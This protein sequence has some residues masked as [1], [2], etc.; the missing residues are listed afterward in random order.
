LTKFCRLCGRLLED[1]DRFCDRCGTVQ[2]PEPP[3]P[4]QYPYVGPPQPPP[5]WP[6]EQP[7]TPPTVQ[8]REPAQAQAP[9]PP[10]PT[11]P[12]TA[13]PTRTIPI[14]RVPTPSYVDLP[15]TR[16][17]LA[18][19]YLGS[20]TGL[21]IVSL[22]LLVLITSTLPLATVHKY[23]CFLGICN[24]A[25]TVSVTVVSLVETLPLIGIITTGAVVMMF[26]PAISLLTRSYGRIV[27]GLSYLLM[28]VFSM[29]ALATY[30]VFYLQYTQ[31]PKQIL[32]TP[33][34]Q[35]SITV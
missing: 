19:S 14:T 32:P 12:A 16:H 27:R 23:S 18:F 11:R 31:F 4:I 21:V 34:P 35:Y 29:I 2:P 1:H 26:V 3:P 17:R 30:W 9:T 10:A 13:P 33:W 22:A 6:L 8:R 28:G 5:T 20:P 25:S 15:I 7:R 24:E